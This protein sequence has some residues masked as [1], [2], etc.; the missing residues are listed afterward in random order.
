M[1]VHVTLQKT[2]QVY[3]VCA[4]RICTLMPRSRA[5]KLP[6]IVTSR[7]SV[8]EMLQR[9]QRTNT[10]QI[11]THAVR[12]RDSVI[13]RRRALGRRS[14]VHRTTPMPVSEARVHAPQ[15]DAV[16]QGA[17]SAQPPTHAGD[18]RTGSVTLQSAARDLRPNALQTHSFPT[19]GHASMRRVMRTARVRQVS[20][21]ETKQLVQV[22][23][24]RRTSFRVVPGRTK[25]RSLAVSSEAFWVRL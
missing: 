21:W 14:T 20:A 24:C 8:W 11:R 7:R 22:G 16:A 23:T 1:Q 15:G 5:A 19:T 9:A 4:P 12:A 3:P 10:T 2:A 13:Q 18:R 6:E 25:G 17:G